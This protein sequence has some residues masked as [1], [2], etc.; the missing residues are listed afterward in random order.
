MLLWL[1]LPTTMVHVA[2]GCLLLLLLFAFLFLLGAVFLAPIGNANL[3]LFP[4]S[5]FLFD[6]RCLLLN[7]RSSPHF[8]QKPRNFRVFQGRI[9]F[10]DFASFPLAVIQKGAHG[11]LR[12]GRVLL[13]SFP[14]HLP[15]SC[16]GCLLHQITLLI[17][18]R[19]LVPVS[20]FFGWQASPHLRGTLGDFRDCGLFSQLALDFGLLGHKE[21]DVTTLEALGRLRRFAKRRAVLLS[22]ECLLAGC[23]IATASGRLYNVVVMVLLEATKVFCCVVN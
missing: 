17:F 18:G 3:V 23:M 11:T 21:T 7:G 19:H 1:L 13:G 2:P 15:W 22:L 4:L 6:E 20:P 16:V 14:R 8:S 10:F 5:L 12:S 9:G